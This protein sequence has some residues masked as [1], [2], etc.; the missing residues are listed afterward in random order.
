MANF[1]HE[2]VRKRVLNI[3]D[4]L[5]PT[6]AYKNKASLLKFVDFAEKNFV[7]QKFSAEDFEIAETD[8]RLL[9]N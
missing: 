5:D 3:M 2:D 1:S 6:T 8:S 4:F 9:W 7:S